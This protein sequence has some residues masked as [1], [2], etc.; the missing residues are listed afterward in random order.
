MPTTRRSRRAAAGVFRREA[1]A[2]HSSG[3]QPT[4]SKSKQT[5]SREETRLDTPVKMLL[6]RLKI[7]GGPARLMTG[8][9]IWHIGVLERD[10]GAAFNRLEGHFD[11]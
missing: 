10:F 2:A 6:H 1:T 5:E 7:V 8:L 4:E 11:F 3:R 9:I